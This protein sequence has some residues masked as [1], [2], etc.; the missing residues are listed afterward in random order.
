MTDSI[1]EQVHLEVLSLSWFRQHYI[2]PSQRKNR[3]RR[4]FP[5]IVNE[6]H[7]KAVKTL[8][9]EEVTRADQLPDPLYFHPVDILLPEQDPYSCR[10]SYHLLPSVH[11]KLPP[12]SGGIALRVISAVMNGMVVE[13][14][15]QAEEGKLSDSALVGFS[16]FHHML[17]YLALEFPSIRDEA[18]FR[19]EEFVN[20]SISRNKVVT[21]DLGRLL[22]YLLLCNRTWDSDFR[23]AFLEETLCRQVN[24]IVKEHL[25]PELLVL[26][27]DAVSV[28]RLVT[29]FKVVPVFCVVVYGMHRFN[30]EACVVVVAV[31]CVL[32][33]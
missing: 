11:L 23:E 4:F 18:N 7:G 1:H 26:E 24:W 15:S 3:Q 31:V 32:L 21:K 30:F 19:V 25:H 12:F 9:C 17:L 28:Y 2:S 29:T 10:G 22:V 20:H 27:T 33:G 5:L 16:R 6:E 8:L 14:A 13:F